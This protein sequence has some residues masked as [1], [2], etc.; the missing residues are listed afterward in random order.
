MNTN[1][2]I[3]I[4]YRRDGGAD[5]ALQL[6]QSLNEKGYNVC[7]DVDIIGLNEKLIYEKSLKDLYDRIDNCAD[8]I[9]VLNNTAFDKTINKN[10]PCER[11][12][13]RIELARAIEKEKNIIP[14]MLPGFKFPTQ[15]SFPQDIASIFD[16]N[17]PH[18]S[19]EYVDSFIDK[20]KRFLHSEQ[21]KH[22]INIIQHSANIEKEVF[23]SYSRKDYDKVKS[24]KDAIDNEVGID[25]WMDIDGIESGEQFKNVIIKAINEHNTILFMLSKHSMDSK[26]ALDELAFAEHKKKR[27]VLVYVEP[28]QMTDE[29]FFSYQK[30]DSIIWDDRL[31]KKK[32]IKNLKEWFPQINKI[33]NSSPKENNHTK[34]EA[35]LESYKKGKDLYYSQHYSEALKALSFAAENGHPDAQYFSGLIN[36]LAYCGIN[37]KTQAKYWFEKSAEQGHKYGEDHLAYIYE[38]GE[39]VEKDVEKALYW[40][41]KSAAQQNPDAYFSIGNIYEQGDDIEQNDEK[42]FKY[43]FKAASIGASGY[44]STLQAMIKV[45]QMY[46]YGLGTEQSASQ[47]IKWYKK[48]LMFLEEDNMPGNDRDKEK[49]LDKIKTLGNKN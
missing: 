46:E 23:I 15:S 38:H 34:E 32:L 2:D 35:I 47:A 48:Y 41:E 42:A 24:I 16:Y 5:F 19:E 3:F 20:L 14:V 43:Y 18:Y 8:F 7:S 28:C 1:Y 4:C 13:L 39:G 26:W 11:D 27:I 31:Q 25:C 10:F 36:F 33:Q 30:K 29:F 44:R 40:Y 12:W 37:N 45:A 49:I 22:E 21:N 9:V 17:G 6:Y